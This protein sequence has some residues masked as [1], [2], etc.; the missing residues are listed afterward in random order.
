MTPASSVMPPMPAP[1]ATRARPIGTTAATKVPNTTSR[2]SSA[3]R[4]P[5]PTWP[6]L[7]VLGVEEHGVA[8]ELDPD[9]RAPSD[10][11]DG[12]RE[13]G[14]RRLA[15]LALRHVEGQ[16]GVPDAAV[17][18]DR[19]GRE[20]VGDRRDVVEV[21]DLGQHGGDVGLVALEGGAVLG[22]RRRP[23]PLPLAASGKSSLS[24]SMAR[25]LWLP[26][27][28]KSSANVPPPAAARKKTA[29]RTRTQLAMVRQGCLALAIATARV[30]PVHGRVGLRAA[31][32]SG[33]ERRNRCGER[34]SPHVVSRVVIPSRHAIVVTRSSGT[35][36]AGSR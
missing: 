14:E 33:C 13:D 25:A 20:R 21:G 10:A 3:T 23:G 32:V 7:L 1:T 5:M 29:P 16:L 8:A 31:A 28:E 15:H 11:G 34:S 26:G 12:V 35:G 6:E 4:R 30:N 2:T 9:V 27:A 36:G 18:R 24:S 17:R 22:L 19:A